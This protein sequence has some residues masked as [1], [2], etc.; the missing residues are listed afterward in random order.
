MFECQKCGKTFSSKSHYDRHLGILSNCVKIELA[1]KHVCV[2]CSASFSTLSNLNKHL[3]TNTMCSINDVRTKLD[4]LIKKNS[5]IV[6][7]QNNTQNN[8]QN[9]QNTIQNIQN[10]IQPLF[11]KNGKENMKHITKEVVLAL[12]NMTSFTWICT[13]LMQSSY[14][15]RL[16][17][18]NNNWCLA[19]PNNENAAIVFDHDNNKFKRESTKET[20][21]EKFRNMMELLIP[22]LLEIIDEEEATGFLNK[23]QKRNLFRIQHFTNVDELSNESTEIYESIHKMAYK[24]REIPMETWRNNGYK[25]NYLSLKF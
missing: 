16:V 20:I 14:F 19:Y 21:N 11:V 23:T 10:I 2:R 24:Q 15:S 22:V 5:N 13:S 9:V 1:N 17:P 18:E 6:S 3:N 7:I 25:G 4:E 8:T 12:L